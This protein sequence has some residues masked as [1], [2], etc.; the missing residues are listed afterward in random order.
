MEKVELKEKDDTFFSHPKIIEYYSL[1]QE[2]G[3]F[4]HISS[5]E[6]EARNY[7]NL[8]ASALDIVNRPTLDEILSAIVLLISD[9]FL[10]ASIIFLWKPL[11]NRE[12][13]TVK[14]Y[15]NYKRINPNL[16]VENISDFE[17]FFKKNSGIVHYK[18][19]AEAIG[20]T[21]T[22]ASFDT[23]SP[24]LVIPIL[25]PSGLYGMILVGSKL[26]GDAYTKL[27]L[28]YFQ[29]LMSFVSKA[30]Q[31]HL[32]YDRTLRDPKTGLYNNGFFMKRLEGEIARAKR[33]FSKT[34]II[35][36]D[37]DH[38]K[39]FN[40][41]YG[42]VAGDKVLE[43]IAAIIKEGVRNSDIPSRFGGEEFTVLLPDTDR[44]TVLIVAERLRANVESM[45]VEWETPLPQVTISLGL[46][47]FD[48]TLNIPAEGVIKR[49]DEA[50]YISKAMGRNQSN[51]WKGGLLHKMQKFEEPKPV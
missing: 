46:F 49:A 3:V 37:V 15:K 24:E 47:T 42:H 30:M 32:H 6:A 50:L 43:T 35:I 9:R 36:I 33:T 23:M 31:N 14:C 18:V 12:D 48:R 2:I 22:I 28:A 4:S 45:Q 21:E 8:F 44:E 38:F 10:P 5:L 11:Q 17:P 39:I 34:S 13:I 19:F 7:K 1:L 51:V 27:E 20:Q 16:V 26:L 41:K 40:D 25:G 29:N